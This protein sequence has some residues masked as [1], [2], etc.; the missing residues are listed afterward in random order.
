VTDYDVTVLPWFH[1]RDVSAEIEVVC[2]KFAIK[3]VIKQTN[4]CEIVHLQ[5]G[6]C[7]NQTGAKVINISS[8]FNVFSL[9]FV[10]TWLHLF[11][12][13]DRCQ[14]RVTSQISKATFYSFW[15]HASSSLCLRMNKMLNRALRSIWLQSNGID[16][17]PIMIS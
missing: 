3:P 10:G 16:S 1:S 14:G 8:S 11:G 9:I 2:C 7:G 13:F 5:A 6:Q 15:R 4:I 17:R 12:N